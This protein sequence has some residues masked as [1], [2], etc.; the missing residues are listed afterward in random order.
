[1]SGAKKHLLV[2]TTDTATAFKM[3]FD[4]TSQH[5]RIPHHANLIGATAMTWLF[6]AKFFAGFNGHIV[7]K[8]ENTNGLFWSTFY[9]IK[10][11]GRI[12]LILQRQSANA[13]ASIGFSI[14]EDS[15]EDILVVW[16]RTGTLLS[17]FIIYRNKVLQI[18]TNDYEPLNY[19][20]SFGL[21]SNSATEQYVGAF[22]QPL[23]TPLGRLKCELYN[24]HQYNRAWTAAEITA[25]VNNGTVP[26]DFVLQIVPEQNLL[27]QTVFVNGT[28]NDGILVGSNTTFYETR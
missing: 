14:A 24:Y 22:Q 7:G 23:N 20:S 3:V 19:N 27:N 16:N 25:Y 26:T 11:N 4:G 5:V 13:Y 2:P 18:P 10:T 9:F 15:F 12:S 8:I 28:V 17:D 1:M 6:T 21:F